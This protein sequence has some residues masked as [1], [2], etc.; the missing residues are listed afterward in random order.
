MH[1]K[2]Q[3]SWCTWYVSNAQIHEDLEI[4]VFADH[5]TALTELWLKVSRY[6]EALSSE[7]WKA[8][9]PTKGG[10]KSPEG[11]RGGLMIC[12]SVETA[13]NKVAKS[14]QRLMPNTDRLPWLRF[15]V[16]F[17]SCNANSRVY[18]KRGT[19]RLRLS[20]SPS[21]KTN[22]PSGSTPTHPSD[23]SSF[24]KGQAAW[25]LHLPASSNS[26]YSEHVKVFSRDTR[27]CR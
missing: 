18:W 25:R 9:V 16:L 11:S 20:R 24:Y 22:R 6:G 1:Q 5:I 26:S 19:A 4:P 13:P 14:T 27:R 15:S 12:A 2:I 21:A 3:H 17:L 23:Q 8:L 10:L 7:T